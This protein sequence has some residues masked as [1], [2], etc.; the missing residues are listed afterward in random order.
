MQQH[1]DFPTSV[2]TYL[3]C[4]WPHTDGSPLGSTR[5]SAHAACSRGGAAPCA[6]RQ[7]VILQFST[8]GCAAVLTT[9]SELARA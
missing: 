7:I 6:L 3:Y 9:V 4:W 5:T 1:A 8:K 2:D